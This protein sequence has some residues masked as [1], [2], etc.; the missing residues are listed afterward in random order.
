MVRREHKTGLLAISVVIVCALLVSLSGCTSSQPQAKVGDT[1]KVH[2]SVSFTDGTEFQSTRNT[3]P[4]EFTI[5]NGEVIPG[6]D[7]AVIGMSPG[8]TKT[9]TVPPEK[10][11]GPYRQEMVNTISTDGVKATLQELQQAGNLR[12]VIIPGLDPVYTW[13]RDDGTIGYLRFSN[14]T[15]E[16]TTV[17]ENHPL[18]GKDLVFTIT[19]V[20][21][22][23]SPG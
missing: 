16:T 3:T 11:Y 13:Q 9:V 21:I 10:G 8:D 19:L 14:I 22:V 2:Y 20:E 4:L 15:P 23:S 18:A 5:G 17:D 12:E 1:V 6:F 7:E